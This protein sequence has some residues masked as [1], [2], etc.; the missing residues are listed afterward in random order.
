MRGAYY[1]LTPRNRDVRG[2]S[3]GTLIGTYRCIFFQSGVRGSNNRSIFWTTFPKKSY[4]EKKLFSHFSFNNFPEGLFPFGISSTIQKR[5]SASWGQIK[6]TPLTPRT[7]RH[8]GKERF[9]GTPISVPKEKRFIPWSTETISVNVNRHVN[10]RT[11]FQ[12]VFM[13][14]IQK[15]FAN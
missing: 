14:G 3:G 10:L 6:G 8:Y 12:V 15:L 1:P 13:I 9:K 4:T 5:L 11:Q 2:I 7:S